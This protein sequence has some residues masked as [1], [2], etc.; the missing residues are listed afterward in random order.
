M[1]SPPRLPGSV[2]P[3]P[4]PA[5]P[6]LPESV[7]PVPVPARPRLPES[8][9][10][11]PVP[12][13]PR[14]PESVQPPCACAC[15]CVPD[16]FASPAERMTATARATATATA[17]AATFVVLL[18]VAFV[19]ACSRAAGDETTVVTFWGLGR[20][21]EVV[22]ELIP[23]FERE[24]PGITVRVQQIPWTA[25]HEK[26]LTSHVGDASPD[27]AQI[28]NTW[29]A[30][31]TAV[32]ALAPLDAWVASSDVVAPD[33]YFPGIWRT[34]IVDDTVRGVPWYVDTRVI[35]YRTDILEAAGYDSVPQTWA[36][37]L[38]A[39]R[40]IKRHV[41]P[42][43]Y[44]IYLPTNEWTQPVIFG[45]Q[46]GS[47]LLADGGTRG[48]FADP[49]FARGFDFYL[50]L[51]REGL[52][53]TA[54]QYDIANA[55]QEFERG[56]FAMWITGPWNMGEFRRR[57]SPAMQDRW[58]TAPMP[59]PDGPGVSLASGGSLVLFESSPH[60]A[61]A[62]KLIEFLSRPA[63]QLRFYELTGS[64]PAVER[65]WQISDLAADPKAAAFRDQLERVVPLPA[66]PEI[67]S[68]MTRVFQQAEQSIRGDRPAERTLEAL[69]DDVDRIL[70]KRRWLLSRDG[71]GE[72]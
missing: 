50:D 1:R 10:P 12:A 6:R 36:G 69:D 71:A 43:R 21:G 55:Y 72:R 4:V 42:D 41:G 60:K 26:L 44:A 52:A 57:I 16:P 23:E 2:R 58:S 27:V 19:S 34:N 56:L 3:V 28:G 62:W 15:A 14:L 63:Q 59:G 61:E 53:P 32:R 20:E 70:A 37:W 11:V 35:F 66:V 33:A 54:G 45:L 39:M 48:A 65:A 7:P 38:D 47:P 68:I 22:A 46:A 67:E 40:A 18:A 24:N 9:P 64:L 51:Y 30:E 25:A 8:V 5:R 29:V 49:A 13:R 17:R 31:F